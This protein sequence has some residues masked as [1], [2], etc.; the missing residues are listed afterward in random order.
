MVFIMQTVGNTAIG[1]SGVGL[2]FSGFSPSLGI[3]FDTFQNPEIGDPYYDHIAVISNGIVNHNA[4]TALTQ[5][6]QTLLDNPNIEDGKDHLVRITWEPSTRSLMVFVDCQS[7]IQLTKDIVNDIFKGQTSVWWGFSGATG[8]FTNNQTVCL[9]KQILFTNRYTV[10]PGGSTVLVGRLAK[11]NIYQWSPTAGLNNPLIRTPTVRPKKTTTY[12]ITYKNYCEQTVHDT[13]QVIVPNA[14]ASL[15]KD[16]T[17][18]PGAILTLNPGVPDAT[19]QWQDGSSTPSYKVDKAGLYSV[20]ITSK[21]CSS[22]SSI[23]IQYIDKT[24]INLGRDTLLCIGAKML[25]R[26]GLAGDQYKWQDGSQSQDFVVSTAGIYSVSVTLNGCTATD[27]IQVMYAKPLIDLL[28]HDTT[29]C[30]GQ[31]LTIRPRLLPDQ[32]AWQDGSTGPSYKP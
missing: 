11:D 24:A 28:G 5:P 2:G 7:R 30:E 8:L 12:I 9:A 3:E 26:S 4:P 21:V 16:T 23:Q 10:C 1:A 29:L 32:I 18:C 22:K 20:E 27:S 25:L 19:Y 14:I 17:L 13:I 31:S 6:I 15:G